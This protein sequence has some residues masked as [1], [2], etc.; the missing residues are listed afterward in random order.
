MIGFIYRVIWC[1]LYWGFPTLLPDRL[2]A[3][4]RNALIC[5]DI[6]SLFS[7][8]GTINALDGKRLVIKTVVNLFV[9]FHL[10]HILV[11]SI[12]INIL[13]CKDRHNPKNNRTRMHDALGFC[14]FR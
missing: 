7:N 4:K 10:I 6:L 1:V 12:V 11:I 2:L 13:F 14:I 5:N 9:L 8:E 3:N